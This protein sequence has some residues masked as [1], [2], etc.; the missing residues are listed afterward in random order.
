MGQRK[1]GKKLSM[2]SLIK[3]FIRLILNYLN[4][5]CDIWSFQH[6]YIIKW[7]AYQPYMIISLGN[8]IREFNIPAYL[9]S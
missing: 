2:V 1:E 8:W 3:W 5:Y 6:S 4:N 7:Q 9:F